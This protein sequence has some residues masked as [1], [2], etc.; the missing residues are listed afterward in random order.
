MTDEA[1]VPG[2]IRWLLVV[3]VAA[4]IAVA[5]V[6][7][8]GQG[9]GQLGPLG[10]VTFDLW[11]H[12]S[13][14]FVLEVAVIYGMVGGRGPPAV[15]VAL[16]PVFVVAYSCLVEAMQLWIS[17]RTFSGIDLLANAIGV[18]AALACYEL[19]RAMVTREPGLA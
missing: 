15:S 11:L 12:A 6:I 4:T 13:A 18:L 14:Y 3:T 17:Y 5:A 16:T 2:S 1:Y 10:L 7:R 19:G 8:P 9:I